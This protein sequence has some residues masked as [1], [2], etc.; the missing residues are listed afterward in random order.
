M[1]REGDQSLRQVAW[2]LAGDR[3]PAYTTIHAWGEGLNGNGV[4]A[5]HLSEEGIP[6]WDQ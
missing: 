2:S 5:M 4:G 6:R 3:P 1:K